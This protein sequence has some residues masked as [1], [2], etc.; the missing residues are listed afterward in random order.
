MKYFT[1]QLWRDIN[2]PRS[3][4]AT[5]EWDKNLAAYV[6]E[7]NG[8]LPELNARARWFFKRISLHDGTLTRME[9]GDRLDNPISAGNRGDVNR[10]KAAVRLF[11]LAAEFDS[12]FTL[13]YREVTRVELNFPGKAELFSAGQYPNFG[14][15]GYDELSRVGDGVFRHEV[16]F[17]SGSTIMIDFQKFTFRRE[18]AE[19]QRSSRK[20]LQR[21]I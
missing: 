18:A 19:R 14:D 4:A 11:V 2:S 20:P 17:S 5:N 16:L 13:E 21:S 12:I 9:V 7:L 1:A 15:W 6:K 8:F 10:R 3:K